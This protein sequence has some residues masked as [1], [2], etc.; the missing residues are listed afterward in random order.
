MS[1]V[2]AAVT[3]AMPA[4][5]LSVRQTLVAAYRLLAAR[6]LP[7]GLIVLVLASVCEGCTYLAQRLIGDQTPASVASLVTNGGNLL[8]QILTELMSIVVGVVWF[9]IILLG[10]PH[11]GRA[12]LRFG[13]RELRYLGVD[14]LFG[15]IVSAPLMIGGGIV[16]YAAL[17]HL[18]E[19]LDWL[20]SYLVPL[21]AGAA[22]WSA[23][24]AA[25]LG[26]AFPA[27]ATDAAG[28]SIGVSLQ[29]SRGQWLPLFVAFL[30]GAYGWSVV[31]LAVLYAV[32]DGAADAGIIEFLTVALSYLPRLGFLAVSAVAYG[33]L[34]QQSST[35]VAATFD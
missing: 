33:L 15:I 9:R 3:H 26:L 14:V 16:V 18:G 22:L 2:D 8:G 20:Y 6:A 35:A 29:I 34:Q 21:A 27:I 23:A 12:Y 31:P 7:F 28:G 1:P 19:D 13:I 4:A 10:E 24:C 25:W 32:P 17:P 11:R 30:V 5:R